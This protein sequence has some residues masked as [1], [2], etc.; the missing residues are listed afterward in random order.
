MN[1]TP[2]QI[3]VFHKQRE[4]ICRTSFG[5]DEDLDKDDKLWKVD[6]DTWD[7]FSDKEPFDSQYP[8]VIAQF[9]ESIRKSHDAVWEMIAKKD[10]IKHD[11]ILS[12]EWLQLKKEAAERVIRSLEWNLRIDLNKRRSEE[13]RNYYMKEKKS[14]EEFE[15][16]RRTQD[17]AELDP[18][19][20]KFMKA[21]PYNIVFDVGFHVIGLEN[22]DIEA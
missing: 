5:A 1:S 7:Y 2:Q 13:Y 16:T 14:Y 6:M 8:N 3:Y 17:K 12:N 10:M 22:E 11:R 20:I 4:L 19:F 9:P 18:S 15:K 21:L